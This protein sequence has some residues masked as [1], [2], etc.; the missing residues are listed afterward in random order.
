MSVRVLIA[1]DQQ[2]V[3]TGF[4]LILESEGDI[5]VVGEAANGQEAVA[6]TRQYQPDV[7]LMDIRMPE[8]DG[9]EATRQLTDPS[10]G[11]PTRVLILT[12][13]DLDEY[14]F[15]SLRAG[16][17]GFLLKDVAASQLAAGVRMVATGDALLSPTITR[18]LIEQFITSKPV[19]SPPGLG[20]LTPRELEIFQLMAKGMSN[21]EIGN[22]LF[23]GETTVKTHVTRLMMKLEVRD[24]VQAVVLAYE[25]GIVKPSYRPPH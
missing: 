24:R 4:R 11:P 7:V 18:R 9:I 8:L 2:L 17:S 13:F 5:E 22:A 20:K 23:I 1:D 10:D 6:L 16:A 14:V 12:T 25:T 3:R 19:A 15:D 21:T